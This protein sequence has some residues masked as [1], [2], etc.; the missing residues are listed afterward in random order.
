MTLR[1]FKD[2]RFHQFAK[3]C[4]HNAM[5]DQLVRAVGISLQDLQLLQLY[6]QV[7]LGMHN[8]MENFSEFNQKGKT[9]NLSYSYKLQLSNV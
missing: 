3:Q 6:L 8:Y 9:K 2:S 4:W 7:A 1:K 5:Q